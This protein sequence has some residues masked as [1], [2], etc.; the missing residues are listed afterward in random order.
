MFR[1][2]VH[3]HRDLKAYGTQILSR[4]FQ[5]HERRIRCAMAQYIADLFQ[6]YGGP[7][8]AHR[9]SM[10]KGVGATLSLRR[11]SCGLDS[12]P[13]KPVE[14]RPISKWPIRGSDSNEDFSKSYLRPCPAQISQNCLPHFG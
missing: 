3:L 11:H 6:R 4:Q 13:N 12:T 9:S 10:A 14:A 1:S 8:H 7:Y 5:V 2:P